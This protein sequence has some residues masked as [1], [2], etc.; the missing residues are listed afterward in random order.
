MNHDDNDNVFNRSERMPSLFS[1]FYALDERD[2]EGIL[3]NEPCG[4]EI[5]A[6]LPS[7]AR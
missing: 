5:D 7:S 2:A 6:V 1:T 4:F 3:E